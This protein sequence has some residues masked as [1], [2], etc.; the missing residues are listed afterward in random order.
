MA[1]GL[2]ARADSE[3]SGEQ[4]KA[5]DGSEQ[6]VLKQTLTLN[7]Y[8]THMLLKYTPFLLPATVLVHPEITSSEEA[9]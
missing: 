5:N 1:S 7:H 3:P 8:F 6:L 4:R 2:R 9:G